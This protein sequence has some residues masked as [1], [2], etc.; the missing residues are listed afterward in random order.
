MESTARQTWEKNTFFAI[1][2]VNYDKKLMN[3]S[4]RVQSNSTKENQHWKETFALFCL[5]CFLFE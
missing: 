5:F 3:F 1:V 4:V 2:I